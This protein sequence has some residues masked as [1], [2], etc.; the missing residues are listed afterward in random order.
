MS[1]CPCHDC[2]NC[3]DCC[4]PVCPAPPIDTRFYAQLGVNANP[5][6]ESTLPFFTV[7]NE[8]N[9]ITADSTGIITLAAG[10]I[11]HINYIFLAT[12]ETGNYYQIVPY[13]NNSP[14]LLYSFLS[15]AS[16]CR[17]SSA[18]GG[19]LTNQA[20][21]QD[22]ALHFVLTYSEGTNNIDISGAV[23]IFPLAAIT[24]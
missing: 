2:F 8:G 23:S 17:S 12:P 18:S 5:A 3:C 10:Y 11:Y 21:S 20:I 9:R 13:L 19:F 14:G 1:S 4:R 22:A 24:L 15:Q 16:A 6:S 7:F